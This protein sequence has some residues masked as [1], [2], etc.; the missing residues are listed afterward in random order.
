[1]S[2]AHRCFACDD[3]SGWRREQGSPKPRASSNS[4]QCFVGRDRAHSLAPAEP[5][6]PE[7]K[8]RSTSSKA[9]TH[10]ISKPQQQLLEDQQ[11][12]ADEETDRGNLTNP[13][14]NH[15]D[16]GTTTIQLGEVH[17]HI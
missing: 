1:V 5:Q 10:R 14:A 7:F 11:V 6:I 2:A 17:A 16:S 4:L 12:P 9:C 13:P 15:A 8:E 3:K